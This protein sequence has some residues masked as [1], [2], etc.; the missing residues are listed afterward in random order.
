MIVLICPDSIAASVTAAALAIAQG[1]TP[2]ELS[3]LGIVFTQLG[4][5]LATISE[6]RQFF[7]NSQKNDS[8]PKKPAK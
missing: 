6:S 2:D 1:K 7:E 5:T 3:L 4:D 8:N